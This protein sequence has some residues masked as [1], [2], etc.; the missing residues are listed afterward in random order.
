MNESAE[1]LR[2]VRLLDKANMRPPSHNENEIFDSYLTIEAGQS[3][4]WFVGH[5]NGVLNG[6]VDDRRVSIPSVVSVLSG[7]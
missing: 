3:S 4:L 6:S 5:V 2:D 7:T 1:L